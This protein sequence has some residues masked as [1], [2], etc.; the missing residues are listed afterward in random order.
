MSTQ[1]TSNVTNNL[2]AGAAGITAVSFGDAFIAG[3]QAAINNIDQMATQIETEQ[4]AMVGQ[5]NTTKQAGLKSKWGLFAQA[6]AKALQSTIG[7][8]SSATMAYQQ[9]KTSTQIGG[10]KTQSDN[11]APLEKLTET[12][13]I[14]SHRGMTAA[15]FDEL[16]LGNKKLTADDLNKFADQA[17]PAQRAEMF[18]KISELKTQVGSAESALSK[19]ETYIQMGSRAAEAAVGAGGDLTQGY[20]RA[21]EEEQKAEGTLDSAA[22]Q[23]AQGSFNLAKNNLD[24]LM[25]V[26]NA[27]LEAQKGTAQATSR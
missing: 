22:G 19:F 17:S 2:F 8:A 14:G 11:L 4:N 23:A 20:L 7:M 25:S 10:L 13:R 5:A 16:K 26:L 9:N 15:D 12:P 21:Q 3:L 1:T 18:Q 27:L 6:G 24:T